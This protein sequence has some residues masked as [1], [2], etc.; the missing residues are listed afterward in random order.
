MSTELAAIFWHD[1]QLVSVA[2][3]TRAR[4]PAVLTLMLSLYEG[5]Q[6]PKRTLRKITCIDVSSFQSSLD[7]RE[8]QDNASAGN[9]VDGAVAPNT[10]HLNLTGGEIQVIARSFHVIAC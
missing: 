8:L 6:S 7:V 2:F 10:L 9:I 4:E 3:E 5:E 1:G